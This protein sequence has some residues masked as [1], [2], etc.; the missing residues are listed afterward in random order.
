MGRRKLLPL[1][2]PT[3][4]RGGLFCCRLPVVVTTGYFPL[5]LWA[6]RKAR[7]GCTILENAVACLCLKSLVRRTLDHGDNDT[8]S[9]RVRE[10]EVRRRWLRHIQ[11]GLARFVIIFRA[12]KI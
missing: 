11:A 8:V 1:G 7:N 5:A 6:Q 2:F 9:L 10:L 3:P 4:R 12:L